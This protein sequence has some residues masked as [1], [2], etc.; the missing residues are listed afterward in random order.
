MG[1]TVVGDVFVAKINSMKVKC[2][3]HGTDM[4]GKR[5]EVRTGYRQVLRKIMYIG[6]CHT[7][8]C[9]Q[10]FEYLSP[11]AILWP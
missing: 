3:I 6:T 1:Y 4:V 11:D 7:P 2:P 9:N 5:H 10:W 8:E